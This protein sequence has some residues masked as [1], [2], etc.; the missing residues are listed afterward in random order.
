MGR[1]FLLEIGTEE[2]PSRF[3]PPALQQLAS[4]LAAALESWRLGH[5]D[6]RALGTP[7]RLAALVD[8]VAER[9]PDRTLCVQGPPRQACFDA[10]GNPTKALEGFA[11]AQGVTPDR[12]TFTPSDKG[13]RATVE[14]LEK[15][16]LIHI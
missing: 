1:T 12:V 8:N 11:K 15:L 4:E 5:G 7:R 9:Q 16:S 2:L 3:V 13:E 10:N 6:V 14:V